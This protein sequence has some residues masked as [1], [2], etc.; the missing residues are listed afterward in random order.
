MQVGR[1]VLRNTFIELEVGEQLDPYRLKALFD[2]GAE[3]RLKKDV[4]FD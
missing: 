1:L 4:D 2:T 3:S